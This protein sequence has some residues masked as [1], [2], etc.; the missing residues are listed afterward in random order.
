MKKKKIFSGLLKM[1]YVRKKTYRKTYRR[2]PTYRKKT[3]GKRKS[4]YIRRL[5]KKTVSRMA[6]TKQVQFFTTGVN[7]YNS[8]NANFALQTFPCTP[9]DGFLNVLQGVGQGQRIGNKIRIKNIRFKGTIWPNPYNATS[10]P[11]PVPVQIVF[12]FFCNR[13]F[14]NSNPQSVT[15]FLQDGDS[16]RN[17]ENN[18]SDLM[19]KVNTDQYRLL[20]KRIFKIGYAAYE[21]TGIQPNFQAFHNN[22]FKLNKK[23]NIDITKMCY[24]NLRFNDDLTNIP[25]NRGVFCLAQAIAA[26]GSSLPANVLPASMAFEL[27]C[28]YQDI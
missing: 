14:P 8:D 9:Y 17:L 18:L 12:W 2:R 26:D 23:F 16:Q 27:T 4:S 24:K 10:N 6:E 21:G 22:D 13:S 15:G 11:N 28:K 25:R 19:S 20:G 3:Y 7:I 1:V 5:V